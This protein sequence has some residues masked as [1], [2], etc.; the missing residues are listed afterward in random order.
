MAREAG[1]LFPIFYPLLLCGVRLARC[2]LQ[3]FV[4]QCHVS[5]LRCSTLFRPIADGS[6]SAL[7]RPIF[8]LPTR[9]RAIAPTHVPP[10][11]SIS[12]L[13][14]CEMYDFACFVEE[15]WPD[16]QAFSFDASAAGT[17]TPGLASCSS[18]ESPEPEAAVAASAIL[19]SLAL[20]TISTHG[21]GRSGSRN[22][23]A[24]R[25]RRVAY[26]MR[27][28]SAVRCGLRGPKARSS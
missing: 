20:A 28:D 8:A 10:P 27:A 4:L 17:P 11:R 18:G 22:G 24:V 16:A 5:R 26:L 6:V 7:D 25:A 12:A 23:E 14:P 1:S 19:P 9:L 2:P 21:D 13:Y 3:H 15:R